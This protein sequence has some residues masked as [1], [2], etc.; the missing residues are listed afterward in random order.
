M[1]KM[2]TLL[3]LTLSAALSTLLMSL[4]VAAAENPF[5][6]TSADKSFTVATSDGKCGG[7]KCGTKTREAKCG[8]GKCGTKAM[9]GKCGTSAK[10][11]E[12]NKEGKCGTKSKPRE[13][14]CGQ[15]KCGGSK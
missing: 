4:P 10:P 15:G 6:S 7:G 2:K 1:T 14:K 11:K 3:S 13:S 8:E 12:G 5:A 9:E